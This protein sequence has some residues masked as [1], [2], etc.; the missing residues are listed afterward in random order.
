M[1]NDLTPDKID[2]ADRGKAR[3]PVWP[4]MLDVIGTLLLAIGI[5]GQ[6]GG[7]EL[8]FL[9]FMPIKEYAIMLILLGVLLMMPLVIVLIKRAVSTD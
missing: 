6:F 7:E 4:I 5:F 2:G 8:P 9:E 3:F 1:N